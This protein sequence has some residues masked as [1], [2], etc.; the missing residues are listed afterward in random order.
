[1]RA[2]RP[3]VAL[4]ALVATG[5]LVPSASAVSGELRVLYVTATW[6]PMPFA[7]DEVEHVAAET[8]AFFQAASGGRLSMESSIAAPLR[9]P[10]TVFDSC[11]ATVLR[12]AA[13]PSAFAGFDRIAFVTPL[14]ATCGFAG[15]ANPTEVLLNG[16]LFMA[17]AAHELGHT[18]GLGQRAAGT[19][20]AE[21]ARS[22]STG[23]RS[24]SWGAGTAI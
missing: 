23:T 22:T 6:G 21:A 17:L 2:V 9:L 14:V 3:A 20:S 15:E 12:N 1:M 13:P 24:A 19:A 4:L 5:L 16:R 10:R 7:Q 18:L 11:D 8:E